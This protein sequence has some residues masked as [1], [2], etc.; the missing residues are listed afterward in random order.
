MRT[1]YHKIIWLLVAVV[2][3]FGITGCSD[4]FNP[5]TP[6]GETVNP[7]QAVNFSGGYKFGVFKAFNEFGVQVVPGTYLLTY[8]TKIGT[9]DVVFKATDSAVLPVGLQPGDDV[10]DA[11]IQV[12]TVPTTTPVVQQSGA[13]SIFAMPGVGVPVVVSN[14]FVVNPD[15]S[16]FVLVQAGRV[17]PSESVENVDGSDESPRY[18][19]YKTAGAFEVYV[20]TGEY[21]VTYITKLGEFQI[22]VRANY[23]NFF[24]VPLQS[25]DELVSVSVQ[26][27][28]IPFGV[29]AIQDIDGIFFFAMPGWPVFWGNIFMINYFFSPVLLVDNGQ[30]VISSMVVIFTAQE[31][32]QHRPRKHYPRGNAWGFWARQ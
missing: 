8:T 4:T 31:R 20:P 21:L 6:A 11:T 14:I 15:I 12:G 24:R 13:I 10:V 3:M 1:S 22:V 17:V 23:G 27:G 2:T 26:P 5:T 7:Q 18:G 25:G 9:F 32:E 28:L 30:V 19:I 16:S 29:A